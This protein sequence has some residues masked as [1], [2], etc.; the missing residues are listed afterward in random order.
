MLSV[1]FTEYKDEHGATVRGADSFMFFGCKGHGQ[2]EFYQNKQ[3][4]RDRASNRH[5]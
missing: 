3:D 2:L 1:V 4:P 5:S